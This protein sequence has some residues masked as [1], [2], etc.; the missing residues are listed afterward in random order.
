MDS[1]RLRS[2]IYIDLISLL[3]NRTSFNANDVILVIHGIAH[4]TNFFCISIVDVHPR[5]SAAQQ[6]PGQGH[7]GQWTG[8]AQAATTPHSPASLPHAQAPRATRSV[9]INIPYIPATWQ[10]S[11]CFHLFLFRLFLIFM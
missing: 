1:Q 10:H 4:G 9:S 6:F 2:W 3:T 5:H 11:R 7:K 8:Y